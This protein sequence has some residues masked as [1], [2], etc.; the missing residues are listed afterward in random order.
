MPV[1]QPQDRKPKATERVAAEVDGTLYRFTH[2]GRTYTL[3]SAA[4]V[5]GRIDAGVLIDLIDGGDDMAQVRFGIAMLKAAA[6]DHDTMA[7]LRAK[8]V[9]EFSELLADWL[10]W[11]GVNPGESSRSSD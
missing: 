9:S 3:P 1:K 8:P 5:A 4:S 11:S 6:V 7:A 2:D 10:Q